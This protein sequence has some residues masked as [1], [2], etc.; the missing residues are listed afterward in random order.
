M[1]EKGMFYSVSGAFDDRGPS[2]TLCR[3]HSKQSKL[4]Q[5]SESGSSSRT[6]QFTF[7]NKFGFDSSFGSGKWTNWITKELS[8]QGTRADNGLEVTVGGK[9]IIRLEVARLEG[10]HKVLIV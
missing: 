8:S 2:E 4:P 1:L 3:R 10:F 7:T 9:P 5:S 6:R